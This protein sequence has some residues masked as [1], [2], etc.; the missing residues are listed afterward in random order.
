MSK[1]F[2]FQ[3]QAPCVVSM[4][5]RIFYLFKNPQVHLKVKWAWIKE[6]SMAPPQNP[7]DRHPGPIL[8]L[9][10]SLRTR[11]LLGHDPRARQDPVLRVLRNLRRVWWANNRECPAPPERRVG[12]DLKVLTT[13]PDFLLPTTASPRQSILGTF[14]CRWRLKEPI[15]MWDIRIRLLIIVVF[16]VL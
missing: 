12:P 13:C 11:V 5:L 15:L 8:D 10:L 14:L 3:I 1:F 4:H 16:S 6:A 9:T 2:S 7:P